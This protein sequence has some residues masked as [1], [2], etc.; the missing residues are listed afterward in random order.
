LSLGLQ[1]NMHGS[2]LYDT[3]V[4][5]KEAVTDY[6]TFVSGVHWYDLKGAPSFESVQAQ[7]AAILRVRSPL[8]LLD[9]APHP[10][11]YLLSLQRQPFLTSAHAAAG[12]HPRGPHTEE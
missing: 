10:T 4:A 5:V 6:R 8:L 7:V 9:A 3:H 11:A 1:V 2:T 12:S